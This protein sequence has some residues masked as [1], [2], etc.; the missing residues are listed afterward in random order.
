MPKFDPYNI[1]QSRAQLWL[2][3]FFPD[4]QIILRTEERMGTLHLTTLRQAV[5][6]LIVVVLSGWLLISSGLVV[7]HNERIN[8]KN[9]EVKDARSG[10]EQLLAHLTVYKQRIDELT[11]ELNENNESMVS[12]I[13]QQ[14]LLTAKRIGSPTSSNKQTVLRN[15]TN[16]ASRT[17]LAVTKSNAKISV[18]IKR[19]ELEKLRTSEQRLQ[20]RS[21]LNQ[22][23]SDMVDVNQVHQATAFID[24]NKLKVR[25]VIIERDLAEGERNVLVTRVESLEEQLR[26]IEST[27][28]L[29]FHRFA[30]VTSE[31]I[32]EIET[33][34]SS[35]GLEVDDLIKAQ[36]ASAGSGGP[37]IPLEVVPLEKEPLHT[38]LIIT[39][40]K[41]Q[42]LNDLK[43]LLMTM[44]L[45]EPLE[46]YWITSV[47]GIRK[48]PINGKMAR[49]LGL[50]FG[51]PFKSKILSPGEGKVIYAG[52]KGRY[53]LFVEI[54]HG[55]GLISRFG[56]LAAIKVDKGEYVLRGKII[57]LL[58][59]T[60][61][62]TG[63]HLHF[64]VL[65]R[66]K[67]LNPQKFLKAGNSVLKNS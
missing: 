66:G 17:H 31:K 3:R 24:P 35:T 57:G 25:Q 19:L 13:N 43:A 64:E 29:L 41:V 2:Q 47:F 59:N 30:E 34:L 37:Y 49:H 58:G 1:N 6:A 15:T 22:L 45:S 53:G 26:D 12:L 62:S 48:D 4:R 54:D 55:M 8:A 38:S 40:S 50:D 18:A 67:H 51:G 60:G 56:H 11:D 36:R 32:T 61:R 44:P 9:I 42:R 46:K 27:Q 7:S 5:A 21:H 14:V 16:S 63:P 28:L 10:Y 20:L 39:N 65:Y 33:A 23:K 52:K